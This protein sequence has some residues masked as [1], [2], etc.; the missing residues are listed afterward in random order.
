MK[1]GETPT[2]YKTRLNA[3][4]ARVILELKGTK[5]ITSRANDTSTVSSTSDIAGEKAKVEEKKADTGALSAEAASLD[6]ARAALN[7]LKTSRDD[8]RKREWK[9][10][11]DK[12]G[13]EE[14][15]GEAYVKSYMVK[16]TDAAPA[17]APAKA[18][19]PKPVLP[20]GSTTGKFVQGKGYE[21]FKDGKLIGYAQK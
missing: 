5:D 3:M 11:V 20:D 19:A 9:E 16:P 10:M 15:A 2:Q 17:A 8:R 14:A 7:K 6:K 12:H 21:V 13:S 1:Q 18:A 4:A